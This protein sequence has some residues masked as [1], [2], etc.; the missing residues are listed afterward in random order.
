MEYYSWYYEDKRD[1]K[2]YAEDPA[3]VNA[4]PKNQRH[5]IFVAG[6][7]RD[8]GLKTVS[9]LG[10]PSVSSVSSIVICWFCTEALGQPVQV[11]N[12]LAALSK[13]I[14]QYGHGISESLPKSP[15]R[16][17]TVGNLKQY[18]AQ[19]RALWDDI[20]TVSI[21]TVFHDRNVRRTLSHPACSQ[22]K[23]DKLLSILGRSHP[24]MPGHIL[25]SHYS[26]LISPPPPSDIDNKYP[27]MLGRQ[28]MS[29]LAVT[30]LRAQGGVEPQV[31]SHIHGLLKAKPTYNGKWFE[32]QAGCIWL[33][34]TIDHAVK[35]LEQ[36]KGTN[37]I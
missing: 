27:W 26:A 25:H 4:V 13:G 1:F 23:A 8:V 2:I 36:I 9:F 10:V 32:T 22:P 18:Q 34:Q 31:E 14:H 12:C 28:Q 37:A 21:G 30:C 17:I 7:M 15:Q 29:I 35:A 33:L 20:Y 6:L 11:I 3:A 16:N 19:G 5:V 24:D